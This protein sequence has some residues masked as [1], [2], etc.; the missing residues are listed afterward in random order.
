MDEVIETIRALIDRTESISLDGQ[1]VESQA[2]GYLAH[3][4]TEIEA[5]NRPSTKR[6]IAQLHHFWLQRVPWCMPLS[7]DLEK[8]LIQ[9][10]ER[11]M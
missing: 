1:S 8:L 10:E 7:K 6:C 9:L 4:L 11:N 5:G 2:H 3:L